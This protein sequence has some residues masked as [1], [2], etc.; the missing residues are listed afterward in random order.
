M[1]IMKYK[2]ILLTRPPTGSNALQGGSD[3]DPHPQPPLG[4]AYLAGV[5]ERLDD[6]HV[7]DILDGNFSENYVYDVKMAVKKHN[8]DFVGFS[9]FTPFANPALEAATEIKKDNPSILTVMGGPHAVLA[10]VTMKK[11]PALD[12]IVYDEGEG[13]IEEI[14]SGKALHD[15]SGLFIR[16][17][18]KIV[19][20]SPRSYIENMDSLPYPAY[21]KLPHFPDGYHPHPPKSTGKKWCSIMWSRGCPFFC[22]YCNREN[23]FGLQFRN[24]SPEYVI[25]HIRYLHSEYGIEE[26]TFYDDVMSL[27]RKATMKLME[28]MT[29]EKLGFKLSWDAETR[30]DLVDQELLYAMKDA[31][32]RMMSYG[33]EHGEFIHEIKG[34]TATLEQ[35][36]KAIKWTH[37]AK[38]ETVGYYMIGLPKETPETIR[39]TIDFAKKL[40]CTYAMFAITMPFPGNKLYD[41]AVKSGLVKLDD[42]WD[43]FV[44]SGVGAGGIQ[45]PVLTTNSL[46]ASDLGYWAKQAYKE[47][48]FRPSYILNKLLKIRNIKDLKMYYA[49]FRMLKK[50]M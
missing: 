17:D 40:N 14:V 35:A 21:H 49:G 7:L 45:A 46:S 47:Y 5:I 34:G 25:D 27:N 23:S 44:Y 36:E 22:N 2:Q 29:P 4:L 10:E 41:E 13:Q 9:A 18:G 1:S 43:Q 19:P 32:C 48:Y 42:A 15:V 39:K 28:E 8:P 33:I 37:N 20:T 3:R 24:Q 31:G 11:C 16:K 26:L 38:I 50:D 6:V 12:V 30:V